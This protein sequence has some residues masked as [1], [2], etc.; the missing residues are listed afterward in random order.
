MMRAFLSLIRRDT[1]LAIRIGGGGGMA[2]FFFLVVIS[3][4]P[5]GVGPNLKLLGQIAPG[6]LWVAL[7]L[8][9]LLT[10]DRLFQADFEDGSLDV[11]MAGALPLEFVAA[12]KAVSHWLTT[13]MPLVIAAPLLGLLLNLDVAA[14]WPLILAMLVGTPALS[15]LGTVGAALTVSVR[16]GG[17]LAS[18][19]V[20]PFYIPVLIFGVGAAGGASAVEGAG[21]QSLLLLAAVALVSLVLGPVAS[22]AALRANLR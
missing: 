3:I 5:L 18:L 6:M 11:M 15:F 20:I 21:R 9:A 10:L 12:A 22:A 16:R 13:G 2:V 8:S 14:F 1:K 4:V 19:L 7:L 17:L